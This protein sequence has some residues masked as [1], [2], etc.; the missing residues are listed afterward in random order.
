MDGNVSEFDCAEFDPS[1]LSQ[2][3]RDGA[4][5]LNA[6]REVVKMLQ[7]VHAYWR[8]CRS[9]TTVSRPTVKRKGR[10]GASRKSRRK[11]RRKK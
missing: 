11:R 9:R 1:G 7:Q 8:A 10:A 6:A 2:L 4:R 3:L 5:F